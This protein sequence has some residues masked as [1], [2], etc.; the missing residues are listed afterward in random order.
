MPPKKAKAEKA[1]EDE[2]NAKRAA[3]AV[4]D[5]ASTIVGNSSK[6]TTSA[7][8]VAAGTAEPIART[9]TERRPRAE[10]GL[11]LVHWNVGGLNGLLNGKNADERK[12]LLTALVEAERPDVLAISEHKLQE[13]NVA[14]MEAALLELLPGYRA[15]WSVCTAKNGYSGIV[16]LVRETLSP[17]VTLDAVCSELK[18]GFPPLLWLSLCWA[19]LP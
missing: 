1:V 10:G 15:H 14:A 7:K 12:Q 19:P 17:E 3:A 18:G 13:K 5:A 8:A 16:A 6:I 2:P 11:V 9:P 4:T